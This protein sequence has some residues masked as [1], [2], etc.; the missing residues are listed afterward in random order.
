M[1]C[2]KVKLKKKRCL[3]KKVKDT[4][5]IM[6]RMTK[7]ERKKGQTTIYK[8]SHIKLKL[9]IRE[10]NFKNRGELRCSRRVNSSCFTCDTSRVTVGNM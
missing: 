8:T 9:K 1:N 5:G 3:E 4:K 2:R 6:I 10:S 7:R